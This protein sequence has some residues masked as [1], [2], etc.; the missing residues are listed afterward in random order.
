VA[1]ADCTCVAPLKKL[2][3]A[4]NTLKEIGLAVSINELSTVRI[5]TA[6]VSTKNCREIP[7]DGVRTVTATSRRWVEMIVTANEQREVYNLL[8]I[9]KEKT[10]ISKNVDCIL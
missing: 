3:R 4:I 7:R 8:A 1:I 5:E 6:T 9:L 10:K 2:S